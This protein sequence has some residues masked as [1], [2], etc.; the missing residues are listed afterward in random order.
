MAQRFDS[1]KLSLAGSASPLAEHAA[2]NLNIFQGVFTLSENGLLAYQGGEASDAAMQ[3]LWYDRTGK[4]VAETGTPGTYFNP[5][6]S[7]D[8]RKMAV[9][10]SPAGSVTQNIWVFDLVRGIKTRL[11]F[12]PGIDREPTWSPDG[13]S[14]V[15]ISDS[16]GASHVFMKAAD[17]TG[18]TTPLVVDNASEFLPSFSSDA[19]YVVMQRGLTEGNPHFGIWAMPLFGDRKP[20]AAVE[21]QF[22][23][24]RPAL[25]PDGKWIA[26]QSSEAGHPEIF[27]VPFGRGG[28]KWLVSTNGGF[29]PRWR[30]D[31]KELFYISPDYKVMAAAITAQGMSLSVGKVEQL[32][33][34]YPAFTATSFYDVAPDGKKFIIISRAES[35]AAEP[36]TLVVNWTALLNKQ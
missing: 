2:T 20:F 3:L 14:V 15:F 29:W 25:S 5:A 30:P 31:G 36:L 9:A 26:Y 32:F 7:P 8:G 6:V 35:Q 23:S 10:V 12:D 33:Q 22:D 13:K 27:V 28:G 19:R 18:R 1:S 4:K 24:I 21:G 34:A 16:E 11:T 17:G